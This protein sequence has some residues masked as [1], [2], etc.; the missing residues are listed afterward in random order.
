MNNKISGNADNNELILF[1][2]H[3]R[4]KTE[5]NERIGREHC[6]HN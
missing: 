6:P 4:K 2:S 1:P 5:S 3:A